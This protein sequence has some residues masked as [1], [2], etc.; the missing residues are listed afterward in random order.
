MRNLDF[1]IFKLGVVTELLARLS[2]TWESVGPGKLIWA[3]R[4]ERWWGA[5][6]LGAF[7]LLLS[8]GTSH[9]AQRHGPRGQDG[10]KMGWLCWSGTWATSRK[11]TRWAGEWRPCLGFEGYGVGNQGLITAALPGPRSSSASPRPCLPQR[12]PWRSDDRAW[13]SEG[14]HSSCPVGSVLGSGKEIAVF[15]L[16]LWDVRHVHMGLPAL[17]APRYT[18][19]MFPHC[20]APSLA[21]SF[22]SFGCSGS[23]LQRAGLS[24]CTAQA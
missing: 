8:P 2:V 3:P 11:S 23:L 6:A 22:F 14:P 9:C 24:G 15:G 13:V 16:L 1:L 12:M 5:G 4:E 21:L 19:S 10:P 7:L 20:F 17:S 18:I